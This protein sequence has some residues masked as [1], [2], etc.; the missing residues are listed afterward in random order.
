MEAGLEELLRQG[1]DGIRSKALARELLTYMRH[2]D[3]KTGPA[4]GEFSDR[5]MAY[6]IAQ[7]VAREKLLRRPRRR[8]EGGASYLRPR[9]PITGY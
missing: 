2:P 5:L 6:M 1:E 9:N 8:L 4:P 3:G 7:Q